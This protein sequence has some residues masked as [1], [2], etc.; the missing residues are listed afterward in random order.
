MQRGVSV[1]LGLLSIGITQLTEGV[2]DTAE[3]LRHTYTLPAA[4]C[5]QLP[6]MS[7]Q[8]TYSFYQL[9]KLR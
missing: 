1:A 3:E 6:T 9:N 2:A 4:L 8:A 7:Y 5:S